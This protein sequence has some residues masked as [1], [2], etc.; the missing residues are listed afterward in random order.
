MEREQHNTWFSRGTVI[1]GENYCPS[2]EKH[3]CLSFSPFLHIS[4]WS[5]LI[6]LDLLDQPQVPG[7]VLRACHSHEL[8]DVRKVS[9]F[10]S[11]KI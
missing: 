1:S 3:I 2:H 6:M 9:L 10:Y 7:I 4:A 5:K 8:A 11:Y